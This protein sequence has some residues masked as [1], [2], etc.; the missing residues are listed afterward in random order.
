MKITHLNPE[1]IM[2]SSSLLYI[3]LNLKIKTANP[4]SR[5]EGE[6]LFEATAADG[7]RTGRLPA[8]PVGASGPT[9]KDGFSAAGERSGVVGS[10]AAKK[11]KFF[12]TIGRSLVKR[13]ERLP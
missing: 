1:E 4:S 8:V 6:K 3:Q 11:G 9:G 7:V 5:T 13:L 2:S 10:G 12:Q